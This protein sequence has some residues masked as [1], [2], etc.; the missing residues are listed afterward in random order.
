M[1]LPKDPVILLSFIN[2]KLRDSY[3]S[4]DE[5]CEEE[6]VSKDEIVSALASAGFS[7][8]EK[9]NAFV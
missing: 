1:Q 2:M 9:R 7:Y 4:L 3:S 6:G 8:D 5:L